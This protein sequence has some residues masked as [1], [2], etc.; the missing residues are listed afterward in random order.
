MLRGILFILLCVIATV[1]VASRA[2]FSAVW[3]SD[4][5]RL[6]GDACDSPRVLMVVA[7]IVLVALALAWWKD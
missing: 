4:V 1:Y 6:A 5:C 2:Q 7:G 3:A